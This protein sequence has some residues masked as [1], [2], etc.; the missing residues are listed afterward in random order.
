[1]AAGNSVGAGEWFGEAG[2]ACRV[3]SRPEWARRLSRGA[4][5]IGRKGKHIF[6]LKNRGINWPGGFREQTRGFQIWRA[7]EKTFSL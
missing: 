5:M 4:T 7:M 1:M 2:P 3:Q 6:I